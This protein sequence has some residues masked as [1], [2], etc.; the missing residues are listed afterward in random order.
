MVIQFRCLGE[1]VGHT[2]SGRGLRTYQVIF[3]GSVSGNHGRF[4]IA[5]VVLCRLGRLVFSRGWALT[6]THVVLHLVERGEKAI[7]S[8]CSGFVLVYFA[9]TILITVRVV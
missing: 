3:F 2:V 6:A 8:W 5:V 7:L 4:F 9:E 1:P